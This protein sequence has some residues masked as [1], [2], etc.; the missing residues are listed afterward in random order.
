MHT[1]GGEEDRD[2]DTETHK[3]TQRHR[4]RHRDTETD[5]EIERTYTERNHVKKQFTTPSYL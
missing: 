1:C 2:T 5:K 3:E 4:K